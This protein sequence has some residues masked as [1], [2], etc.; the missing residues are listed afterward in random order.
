MPEN[1]YDLLDLSSDA[2]TREVKKAYRRKAREYHPDVNDDERASNQFKMVRRA[3]EVLTDSKERETYDRMGH[4]AYVAKHMDGIEGQSGGSGS[5]PTRRAGKAAGAATATQTAESQQQSAETAQSNTSSGTERSRSSTQSQ[6]RT[7]GTSSS[8]RGANQRRRG[9]FSAYEATR[10]PRWIAAQMVAVLAVLT[11]AGG[12]IA[13]SQAGDTG[14]GKLAS[15]LGAGEMNTATAV[16]LGSTEGIAGPVTFVRDAVGSLSLGALLAFGAVGFPV[17]MA[18]AAWRT[19][20]TRWKAAVVAA[21]GP[22][23]AFGI[24]YFELSNAVALWL[25]LL[26]VLPLAAVALWLGTLVRGN[27]WQ[28]GFSY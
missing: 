23:V 14:M 28:R 24:T 21:L 16:L 11:Y 2:S 9:D 8:Q 5:K 20:P 7:S 27:Q 12:L 18:V 19:G 10:A 13:F 4:S 26:V 6:Q 15:A 17:G 25:L 22:V 3:Y 1:F